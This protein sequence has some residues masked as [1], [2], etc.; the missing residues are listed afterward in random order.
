MNENN[1]FFNRQNHRMTEPYSF[2]RHLANALEWEKRNRT[3]TLKLSDWNCGR[4]DPR[5]PTTLLEAAAQFAIENLTTY[6]ETSMTLGLGEQVSY[7]LRTRNHGEFAVDSA[8]HLYANATQALFA[9]IYA[10]REELTDPKFLLIHPSYYSTHDALSIMRISYVEHWRKL[11]NHGVLDVDE[12]AALWK[13]HRFNAILLTDP[14]YSTGI[15]FSESNL[16]QTIRFAEDRDIWIMIDSAF[17][18]LTWEDEDRQWLD[19][20]KI[21]RRGFEKCIVIDSPSKRLFTNN[22]KLGVVHCSKGL[23]AR[24][25]KFSDSFM[26]NITGMQFGFAKAIFDP[27]NASQMEAICRENVQ[28][29]RRHYAHLISKASESS[30]LFF[31]PP[32]SGFHTM[33]FFCGIDTD[34][35]DPM[36]ACAELVERGIF[37]LPTNDYYYHGN[38]PFGFRINLMNSPTRWEHVVTRLAVEGIG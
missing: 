13:Q 18:G 35:S 30:K 29:I 5:V 21:Q 15:E 3:R 33:L 37:A 23:S 31:I 28:K 22:L 14:M 6:T 25:E 12:L 8:V 2:E 17:G 36:R 1:G 9:S 20:R 32:D 27:V 10:I 19:L 26:G 34:T 11:R 24:F 38:D 7:W 4:E 16:N